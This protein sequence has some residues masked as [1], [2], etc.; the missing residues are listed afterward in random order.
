[1]LCMQVRLGQLHPSGDVQTRMLHAHI[2]RAH[3]LALVPGSPS[4]FLSCGEDGVVCHY[5][6]RAPAAQI[7]QRML[8]CRK[9]APHQVRA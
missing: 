1:M 5:D 7:S 2:W 6:I 9:G 3:K 8:H 4:C